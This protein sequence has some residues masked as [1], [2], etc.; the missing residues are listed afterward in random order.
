MFEE[1]YAR[2]VRDAG[3]RVTC[4][5]DVYAHRFGE[6]PAR[7]DERQPEAVAEAAGP[8]DARVEEGGVT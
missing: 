3:Y 7:G 2:R 4:A 5:Y 1:D 6:M 8:G